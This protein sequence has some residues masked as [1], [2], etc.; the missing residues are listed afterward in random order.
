[1]DE[2]VER[3][4]NAIKTVTIGWEWEFE[5][6]ALYSSYRCAYINS[7]TCNSILIVTKEYIDLIENE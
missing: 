4:L 5:E 1:M 7:K 6:Q 2:K 3:I